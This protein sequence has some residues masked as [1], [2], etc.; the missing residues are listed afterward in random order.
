MSIISANP[1]RA[2][3]VRGRSFH[4]IPPQY[5]GEKGSVVFLFIYSHP[6]GVARLKVYILPMLILFPYFLVRPPYCA[7][8]TRM[9]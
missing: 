7:V 2:R 5:T 6:T 9:L 4:F 1:I 8:L 3:L